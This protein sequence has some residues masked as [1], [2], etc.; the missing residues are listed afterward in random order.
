[1]L[2]AFSSASLWLPAHFAS[3]SA[4]VE[5]PGEEESRSKGR[6]REKGS[7]IGDRFS[8]GLPGLM[9]AFCVCSRPTLQ[10]VRRLEGQEVAIRN[11]G[12]DSR[13][14]AA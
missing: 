2:G 12:V 14:L 7:G 3:K 11:T 10:V 5:G 1:M 4:A 9:H 13:L 6:C 8:G